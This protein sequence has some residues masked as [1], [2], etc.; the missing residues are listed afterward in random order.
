MDVTLTHFLCAL[1]Y[2]LHYVS[3]IW[4]FQD[5]TLLIFRKYSFKLLLIG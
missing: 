2:I 4:K 1:V 3:K 5:V